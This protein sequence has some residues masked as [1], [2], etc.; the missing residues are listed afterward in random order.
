MT[1]V[2]H[3]GFIVLIVTRARNYMY[4]LEAGKPKSVKPESLK[5]R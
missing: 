2:S 4:S 5:D 3:P 1:E